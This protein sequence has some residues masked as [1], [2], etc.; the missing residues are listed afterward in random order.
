M[1][2][3]PATPSDSKH[4][5]RR[6]SQ[7]TTTAATQPHTESSKPL[8]PP[9][10]E[11]ML[12][13][14]HQYY[15]QS[16]YASHHSIY[17]TGG[18][19][20]SKDVY[21][22][23]SVFAPPIS[24]STADTSYLHPSSSAGAPTSF[25]QQAKKTPDNA[26]FDPSRHSS[27]A[28]DAPISARLRRPPTATQEPP[29]QPSSEGHSTEE[30]PV[31]PRKKRTR[32]LTTSHQSSVLLALL[33]RT[34]FPT[35]AERE[36][37]GRAIGLTAR[38]VQVWF[39]NQR[40]KQKKAA[41]TGSVV[42]PP[43]GATSSAP[44]PLSRQPGFSALH[45]A[46]M[47]MVSQETMSPPLPSSAV[48]SQPPGGSLQSPIGAAHYG[49]SPPPLLPASDRPQT[50][51]SQPPLTTYGQ[52][53]VE[54]TP[55]FHDRYPNPPSTASSAGGGGRPPTRH[56]HLTPAPYPTGAYADVFTY[57]PIT[58]TTTTA[59]REPG[60][61][62][63]ARPPSA[64]VNPLPED[65]SLPGSTEPSRSQHLGTSP[66]DAWRNKPLPPLPTSVPNHPAQGRSFNW[67]QASPEYDLQPPSASFASRS[68]AFS[69]PDTQVQTRYEPGGTYAHMRGTSGAL[70]Q[71]PST[72]FASQSRLY[73]HPGSVNPSESVAPGS[74]PASDYGT[75]DDVTGSQYGPPFTMPSASS[76]SSLSYPEGLPPGSTSSSLHHHPATGSAYSPVGKRRNRLSYDSSLMGGGARL[77]G[78]RSW[79]PEEDRPHKRS[80]T[81][82][83]HAHQ[84][85]HYP[86]LS[87]AAAATT[88]QRPGIASTA[89]FVGPAP[90]STGGVSNDPSNSSWSTT[91]SPPAATNGRVNFHNP[92]LSQAIF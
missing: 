8:P 35:T 38:K 47:G 70:P 17:E 58:A 73:Q 87:F 64:Q 59:T 10:Q 77:L 20:Q 72:S 62:S 4:S 85:H 30:S 78:K 83:G 9:P 89:S 5:I 42:T 79:S 16:S 28:T 86:S 29:T 7:R 53:L 43:Q 48:T 49:V 34:P 65:R 67:G 25:A 27:S 88:I 18:F 11:T 91:L 12:A 55:Y 26:L 37:V 66:S 44:L 41:Q 56:S 74:F 81:D 2:S 1:S 75:R 84:Q 3:S 82:D 45:A 80:R 57:T 15:P 13:T 21:L 46:R 14:A 54:Q 33:S 60:V 52:S 69:N 68:R 51:D 22:P 19:E 36:E 40:Q 50:I 76:S 6:K 24:T 32:T 61:Q 92:L 63:Y 39:Q 23:D 31:V 90:P 71:L